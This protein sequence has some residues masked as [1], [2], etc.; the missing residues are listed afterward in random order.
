[1]NNLTSNQRTNIEIIRDSEFI[2]KSEQ[3]FIS[4]DRN[5]N[6]IASFDLEGRLILYVNKNETYKR[7]LENRFYK[8]KWIDGKRYIEDVTETLGKIITENA[9]NVAREAIIKLSNKNISLL[10]TLKVIA[11]RNWEWLEND[12]KRFKRIYKWPISIVPPDQYFSIYLVLTEGCAWNKCTFCNLYKDRPYRVKSIDE[13]KKHIIEV[14]T[15][16]GRGIESRKTIFLGDANAI[17]V[18]QELLINALKE[19]KKELDKPVYSFVDAFT[20]PKRKTEN[21]FKEARTVGLKRVYIGLESG[22]Q[23]IL[24]ILNKPMKI[25][26]FIEFTI[27]LKNAGISVSIIVIAGVGGQL[28]WKEHVDATVNVISKLPLEKDDIIYI[29]PLV[30]Y[31]NLPYAHI[32]KELNLGPLN[33]DEILVQMNELRLKIK[34]AFLRSNKTL[35]SVIARYDIR[36]SIY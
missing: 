24:S 25:D 36:E 27:N 19:I 2:I 30:R 20:T 32:E 35:T 33:D 11:S 28:Y 22:S 31:S 21:D 5:I 16:F 23:K 34:E 15:F 13:F 26:E 10:N 6:E 4:V 29:S 1:M 7:S 18:D 12:A 8:V 17:N 3:G 14:K 9:Y